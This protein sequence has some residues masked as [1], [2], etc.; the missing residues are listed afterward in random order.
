LF[1][2]FTLKYKVLLNYKFSNKSME[3]QKSFYQSFLILV[4]GTSLILLVPVVAMM[5]TDEVKWGV[6]DFVLIGALLMG[7]GLSYIVITRSRSSTAFKAGTALA[8]LT[9][10]FMIWANLGVGLIGSG[11]N[12]ANLMYVAVVAVAIIGTV[13]ARDASGMERTM[14][15]TAGTLG[16]IAIVAL[17]AMRQLDGSSAIEIIGVNG[18]FAALFAASGLL[19]RAA[20]KR[21]AEV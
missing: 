4:M 17:V 12:F 11:P 1:S 13:M 19:F 21:R 2:C 7:T 3:K 16:L 8:L 18:F 10:L 14:Y 15:A 5:F 9:G 6:F 20:S